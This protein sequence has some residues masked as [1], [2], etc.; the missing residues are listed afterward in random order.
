MSLETC[1]FTIDSGLCLLSNLSNPTLRF[2]RSQK[3]LKFRQRQHIS[4]QLTGFKDDSALLKH[5]LAYCLGQIKNPIALPVLE[6]VL[7]DKNEDPM[8]RHEASQYLRQY[9]QREDELKKAAEAMGAISSEASIPVLK[10]YL[11]DGNRA[12]RETCEIALA[13]IEWDNSE[14]GKKHVPSENP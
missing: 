14:E 7:A 12:V 11:K 6:R 4:D 10:Q 3:V 13:K 5:E 8:V 2:K 1:H 9:S